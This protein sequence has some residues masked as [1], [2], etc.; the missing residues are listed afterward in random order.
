ME[1]QEEGAPAGRDDCQ[2][3]AT[4]REGGCCRR[5]LP[6]PDWASM[7]CPALRWKIPASHPLGL[8]SSTV[9]TTVRVQCGGA[10]EPL[11]QRAPQHTQQ[12]LGARLLHQTS[13]QGGRR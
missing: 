13:V 3:T 10:R 8:P 6:P 7:I 11:A 12:V 4:C 5:C 9:A 2:R 1:P